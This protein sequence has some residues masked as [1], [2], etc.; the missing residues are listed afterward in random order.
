MSFGIILQARLA[1][2]R[3]PQKVIRPLIDGKSILDIM[4]IRLRKIFGEVTMVLATGELSAN[5][6]LKVF[7]ETNNLHFFSGSENDV[8]KRFIDCADQFGFSRVMRVCADNPFIDVELARQLIDQAKEGN[9]NYTSYSVNQVPAILT[10]YGIFTELIKT[11]SLKKAY[12]LTD[13]GMDREHVTKYIYSH[14]E[15]FSV[16]LSEA[17]REIGE[18]K[19][20]RLTVDT[21]A[22][23]MNAAL[24]LE[25]LK[26]QHADFGYNYRDII[27][28]IKNLEASVLDSMKEQ[29]LENSK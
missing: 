3:L 26:R 7:A 20:I 4:V 9:F 28:V 10:H 1:S 17:P 29:I 19:N 16:G 2:T 5:L 18:L 21:E 25:Q 12:T 14:P 24:V 13:N 6:P 8:L 22:D 27:A 11:E 23:F 15:I